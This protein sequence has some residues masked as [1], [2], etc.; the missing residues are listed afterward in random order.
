MGR[1]LQGKKQKIQNFNIQGVFWGLFFEN[2]ELAQ[3]ECALKKYFFSSQ[4][5]NCKCLCL[6]LNSFACYQK[7][8]K[9]ILLLVGF[10]GVFKILKILDFQCTLGLRRKIVSTG[11][12]GV[13]KMLAQAQPAQIFFQRRLSMRRQIVSTGSVCA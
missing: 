10:F 4:G 11:S 3:A 7:D 12:A 9:K 8:I 13:G 2:F 6:H 1:R 5:K